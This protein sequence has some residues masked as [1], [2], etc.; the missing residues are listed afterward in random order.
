M[1]TKIREVLTIAD[2]ITVI[3]YSLPAYDHDFKTL[4]MTGLMNNK[5]R[6]KIVLRLITKGDTEATSLKL[7]WE[8][9]VGTVVV[10]GSEGFYEHLS[11]RACSSAS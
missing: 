7:Q 1:T 9:L 3:G 5:N 11:R 8:R 10:E 2:D 6:D 4:L